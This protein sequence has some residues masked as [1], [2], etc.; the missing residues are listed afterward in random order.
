MCKC[1]CVCDSCDCVSVCSCDCVSERV[2]VCDFYDWIY[3]FHHLTSSMAARLEDLKLWVTLQYP[4]A[5][6][7]AE[8]GGPKGPPPQSKCCFK[9]LG[10]I[11]AEIYLKCIILVT[12]FQN[13]PSAGGF[14]PLAAVP[15]IFEFCDL[16]LRNVAKFCFSS[17]LWRNRTSK[18]QL[19]RHFSDVMAIV[20]PKNVT[21]N[22]TK[23]FHFASSPKQNF[24][25]RQCAGVTY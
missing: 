24:W 23:F 17:R 19:W 4:F 1:M 22:V 25:P 9:F 15:L 13:S 12:N 5:G 14:L 7:R 16:K 3:S 6:A 21:K 2:C 18:N 8:P 10:W 20:S 11:L